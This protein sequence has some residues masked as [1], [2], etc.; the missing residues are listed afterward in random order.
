[1]NLARLL[2]VILSMLLLGAHFYRAGLLPFAAGSVLSLGLLFIRHPRAVWLM[3]L[4][5]VAGAAEWLRTAAHFIQARQAMGQPWIR[6]AVILGLVALFTLGSA[7]V[8]R[9]RQL[10]RRFQLCK[11]NEQ[12]D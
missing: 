4:L 3:Q 8:F 12:G 2:P 7:L 11:K 1:M 9:N 10:G 6:L 5:L